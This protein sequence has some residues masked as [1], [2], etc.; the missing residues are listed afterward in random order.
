MN[1]IKQ[2]ILKTDF[3]KF[4]RT[5]MPLALTLSLCGAAA[6]TLN[7]A[8]VIIFIITRSFIRQRCPYCGKWQPLDFEY[9]SECGEHLVKKCRQCDCACEFGDKFCKN[10]GSLL[11][12][13]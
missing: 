9:C 2:K 4:F 3:K 1:T 8:A 11:N 5:F 6:F 10:C 12:D 7:L 13:K